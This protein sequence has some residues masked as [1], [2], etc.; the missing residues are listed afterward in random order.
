MRGSL[1]VVNAWWSNGVH[2]IAWSNGVHY[3]EIA[4]C[5]CSESIPELQSQATDHI[6][7]RTGQYMP[8]IPRNPHSRYVLYRLTNSS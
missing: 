6:K 2:Y 5:I 4:M 1:S 8:L 3:S 7:W